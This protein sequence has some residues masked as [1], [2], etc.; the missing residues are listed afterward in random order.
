MLLDDS[1]MLAGLAIGRTVTVTADMI[2]SERFAVLSPR[3]YFVP[4][5]CASN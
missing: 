2:D 3:R 4:R 5:I 1:L